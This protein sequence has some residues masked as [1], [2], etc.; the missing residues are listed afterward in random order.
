MSDDSSAAGSGRMEREMRNTEGQYKWASIIRLTMDDPV[1][2][3]L[4]EGTE[5]IAAGRCEDGVSHTVFDRETGDFIDISC[6]VVKRYQ[7]DSW[8]SKRDIQTW[9]SQKARDEIWA[10]NGE[11]IA[12][13]RIV[14]E[15]TT[16]E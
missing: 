4:D 3:N 11:T 2:D 6:E 14:S 10:E 1:N 13:S 8:M 16:D 15:V 5:M 12:T 7:A 9:A